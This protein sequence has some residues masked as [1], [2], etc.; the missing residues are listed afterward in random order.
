MAMQAIGRRHLGTFNRRH[1]RRGTVWRG[2]YQAY[3]DLG[4]QPPDEHEIDNLMESTLK[5]W[6]LGSAAYCD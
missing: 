3:R 5:G 4:A 2:E 1:G 6:V